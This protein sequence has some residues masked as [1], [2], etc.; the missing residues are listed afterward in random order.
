MGQ[1]YYLFLD[2]ISISFPLGGSFYKPIS[3]YKKWHALFPAM[4]VMWLV[5]LPWDVLFTKWGVW[6][7]NKDY[8]LGV[9]FLNLPVEEWL[10]FLFITYACVFIYESVVMLAPSWS[11]QKMTHSL[12]MVLGPV[13]IVL[14]VIFWG[15][16]Y[17]TTTFLLCGLYLG[18]LNW[19]VKPAWLGR[20]FVA[21]LFM[22]IPFFIING[23]LTGAFTPEPVVWYNDLE[24]LS[25]RLWTIPIEDSIY[26]LFMMLITIHVYESVLKRL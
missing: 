1:Y 14:A 4:A 21:F 12:F 3:F 7:F 26:L 11:P 24:N 16:M 8:L 15:R 18:Y 22:L 23:A 5:Y 17:T 25:I 13:L 19:V 2:L 6:G 9:D 20:F 10:F